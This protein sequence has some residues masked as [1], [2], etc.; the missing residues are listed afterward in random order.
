MD[1]PIRFFCL[2]LILLADLLAAALDWKVF[3][4]QAAQQ[5][6]VVPGDLLTF[7]DNAELALGGRPAL[8]AAVSAAERADVLA[9][10]GA[11]LYRLEPGRHAAAGPGGAGRQAVLA[12]DRA[13]A[14]FSAAVILHH[15]GADRYFR[16]RLARH[17]PRSGGS[18]SPQES[19]R[20]A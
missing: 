12:G 20:A 11:K 17:E 4:H 18:P 14:D 2:P 9:A 8:P 19:L 5:G 10:A 7:R 1:R 15:H 3:Q 13:R 16:L 6:S